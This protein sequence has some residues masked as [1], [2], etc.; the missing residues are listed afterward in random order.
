M[1]CPVHKVF[2]NGEGSALM[3]DIP[4]AAEI[5]RAV[6][7]ATDIPVGVKM[8]LG[9]D[10]ASRNAPALAEAVER[11]GAA[12]LTVHG[13]TRAQMYA[14]KADLAG[15]AEVVRAVSIPVV[16]NGDVTDASSAARMYELTGC[17][18]V[19]VGRG[20]LGNPWVFRELAC[21]REGVPFTPPTNEEKKAVVREHLTRLVETKGAWA[22]PESRKHLAW[23]TKGMP[24]AAA[25]R[26]RINTV[27]ALGEIY[28]LLD[29][30]FG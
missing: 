16:G 15:I 5:V 6:A 13:R 12:F 4:K 8:R 14:G 30:L 25:F 10:D 24:G 1:G 20:A 11:A 23:Y 9:V 19:M 22:L 29:E 26:S 27:S 2:A 28:A 3:K 7:G 18:A 17:A 21:A